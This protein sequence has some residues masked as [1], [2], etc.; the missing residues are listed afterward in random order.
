MNNKVIITYHDV[1]QNIAEETL[2]IES[3]A[4][5]KYQVKNVFF[6]LLAW[7]ASTRERM[8]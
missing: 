3:I 4:N 5:T 7:M 8:C 2:W 6:L 1:T